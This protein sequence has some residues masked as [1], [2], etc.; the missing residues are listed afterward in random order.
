M[1]D[2][3]SAHSRRS[4]SDALASDAP[5][6]GGGTAAAVAGAMGA[7]LAEMVAALTL[8]KEKYAASHDAMRPI[9]R[10]RSA[11]ARTSSSRLARED[12]EA[13]DDVVAARRLPKDTDEQ[14]AARRAANRASPTAARPRCPMRT[15]RAAV[16]LLAALPELVE[17]GNP[18][19]VSDVGRRGPPARRLRRGRA[20]ERRDQPL[21]NRRRRASSPRCSARRPFFRRSRSGCARRSSRSSASASRRALSRCTATA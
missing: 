17:K 14:K 15:A 18:N 6:P 3:S 1:T 10:G 21:G 9:A 8:S 5:T 16:R 7:A 20:P 4:S 19:A 11:G 12:S 13:Y 2:F